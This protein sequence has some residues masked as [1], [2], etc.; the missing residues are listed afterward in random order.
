MACWCRRA[1][2]TPRCGSRGPRQAARAKPTKSTL[3]RALHSFRRSEAKRRR[4]KPYQVFQNK[5]LQALCTQKPRTLADLQGVWGIGEE[6]L[7][8]YGARLL[9]LVSSS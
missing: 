1:R 8:K 5:T 6:R 9:E 7:E 3:E 4:I 2:S